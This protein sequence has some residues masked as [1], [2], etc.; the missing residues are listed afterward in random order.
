M[1]LRVECLDVCSKKQKPKQSGISFR[2]RGRE[3]KRVSE[4]QKRERVFE[5]CPGV[6]IPRT[7]REGRADG[8]G[9]QGRREL[10]KKKEVLGAAE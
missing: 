1:R 5:S 4:R 10:R 3:R 2:E 7:A 9:E 8:D 6:I